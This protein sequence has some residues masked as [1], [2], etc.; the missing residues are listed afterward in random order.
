MPWGTRTLAAVFLL[1]ALAYADRAR[2]A[3]PSACALDL[4]QLRNLPGID[5]R[6]IGAGVPFDRSQPA[7]SEKNRAAAAI[8]F[9]RTFDTML[10][11]FPGSRTSLQ[12]LADHPWVHQ[13]YPHEW[14][15]ANG[16]FDGVGTE[17]KLPPA[18]L[19]TAVEY[20]IRIHELSHAARDL[21]GYGLES[22]L[23]YDI[24][25]R[26]VAAALDRF[27]DELRAMTWEWVY[28]HN[29]PDSVR[30][31]Y[32]EKVRRDTTIDDHTREFL[33]RLFT[34]A[35]LDQKAYIE[36]E[37]RAG[38]YSLSD[39]LRAFNP[40]KHSH[41][42]AK[43]L[44]KRFAPAILALVSLYGIS[45]VWDR[46]KSNID[47]SAAGPAVHFV[48]GDRAC[49]SHATSYYSTSIPAHLC[50]TVTD[51]EQNGRVV[52]VTFEGHP[53]AIPFICEEG[54]C[55]ASLSHHP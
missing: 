43:A 6:T 20:F 39:L 34:D 53:Q 46:V 2:A 48:N 12:S 18:Y 30:E 54:N 7:T 13:P 36:A 14:D 40:P 37:W 11:Y 41:R 19:G 29:L 23:G 35:K 26:R 25:D 21:D 22:R 17:V 3:P 28:L 44:L 47:Q 5:L 55:V 45:K 32:I 8:L 33:M 16:A 27:F 31:G 1:G 10:E 15:L 49:T 50:G 42:I 38:R 24:H 4:C 9:K 51:I 52:Y